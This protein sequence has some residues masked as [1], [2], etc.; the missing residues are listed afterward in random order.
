MVE[1]KE[2]EIETSSGDWGDEYKG[3][4]P[5]SDSNW[6]SDVVQENEISFTAEITFKTE[7]EKKENKFNKQVIQFTIDVAGKE[8]TMEVGCNQYDFLRTLAE[9]KPLIGKT[10]V[11]QRTGVG[12][13]DTRRSI[14]L[15]QE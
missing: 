11:H 6:F 9:N 10:F 1:E 2:I 14:K 13:K 5:T 4:R 7:G 8:K 15:K 3:E 12:Q